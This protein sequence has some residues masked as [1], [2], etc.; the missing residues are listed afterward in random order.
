MQLWLDPGPGLLRWAPV[1]A[2]VF[3]AA[4]LLWR[5]HR[6]RLARV[7]PARATA[8]AAAGLALAVVG[9]VLLVAAFL[10][11]S[12]DEEP[13]AARHLAPAF[14]AAAALIAWGLRHAPRTGAVLG[15]LTLAGSVW[16]FVG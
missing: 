12:I 9:A 5:S 7:V 11:P 4:W 13:F 2:L 16:F 1:Y 14:P 15:A 8:E 6:E 10:A 3:Y